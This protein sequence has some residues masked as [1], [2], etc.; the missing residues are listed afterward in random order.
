MITT[1][2]VAAL[3][4]VVGVIGHWVLRGRLEAEEIPALTVRDFVLPLQ[5][6]TVFVLAFVLVTAI[7]A[8]E[9]DITDDH[10]TAYG[11]NRL[12]CTGDGARTRA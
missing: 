2:V 11:R 4:L 1:V 10:A 7:A 12:P 6:L 8:V 5:T 9:A 3:A